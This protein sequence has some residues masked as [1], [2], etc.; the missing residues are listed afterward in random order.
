LAGQTG[1][2]VTSSSS[3]APLLTTVGD[4]GRAILTLNRPAA[5]NAIDRE[6]V[7]HLS[8]ALAALD[9]NP[10]V[11][12][13]VLAA[14]GKTFSTGADPAWLAHGTSPGAVRADARAFAEML[15][16]LKRLRQPTVAMVQG[17]AFGGGVGLVACCDI[18]I[19]AR[20]ARFAF[21]EVKLGLLPAMISP[22]VALAVGERQ[23][24]RHMLVGDPFDAEEAL[25]LGLVHRVVAAEAL[26]AAVEETVQSLLGNSPQAMAAVKHLHARRCPTDVETDATVDQFVRALASDDGREG[27][28][29][30]R[31]GRDP[32]WPD[33]ELPGSSK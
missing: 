3:D 25:R 13:V 19:A 9:R 28:A 10:A 1:Q 32:V 14:G 5:H 31:A 2:R 8:D 27:V 20:R 4:D 11:R 7:R 6:L 16:A 23:A 17:A 24:Q 15:R 22:Y 30:L 26:T 12:V 18:A 29:A 33:R 21:P